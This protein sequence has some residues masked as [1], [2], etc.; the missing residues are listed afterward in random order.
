MIGAAMFNQMP[1]M[2]REPG[3]KLS[4]LRKCP[5]TIAI[6]GVYAILS[7]TRKTIFVA[8]NNAEFT[9]MTPGILI[10]L[11]KND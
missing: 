4:R 6:N 11:F 3:G 9:E 1:D 2:G 8:D 10:D 7:R 5:K